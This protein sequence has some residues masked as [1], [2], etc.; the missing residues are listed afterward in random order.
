MFDSKDF[1]LLIVT[2]LV[3]SIYQFCAG[4]I[5]IQVVKIFIVLHYTSENSHKIN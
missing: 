5:C 3:A 4:G 2:T 1:V